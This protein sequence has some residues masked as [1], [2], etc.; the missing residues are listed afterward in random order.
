MWLLVSFDLPTQTKKQRH[1]AS[2]FRKELIRDGFVM[3]QFSVYIRNCATKENM[4]VHIK[5]IQAFVPVE[6]HIAVFKITDKQ[7]GDII[8][9]FGALQ[10][11]PPPPL[12]QLELF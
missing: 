10:K 11:P 5:R 7:F 1:D 9:I 3:M 8:N 6:G 12:E 2:I 4:D